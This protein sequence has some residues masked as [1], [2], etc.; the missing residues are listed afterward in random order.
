VKSQVDIEIAKAKS[1]IDLELNSSKMEISRLNFS[2][3]VASL[4]TNRQMKDDLNA[5][6]RDIKGTIDS[7]FKSEK[8]ASTID[9]YAKKYTEGNV[10]NIITN[11]VKINV[12]EKIQKALNPLQEQVSSLSG[13]AK[14]ARLALLAQGDD[15]VSFDYLRDIAFGNKPESNDASLKD[16][17]SATI[18]AIITTKTSVL[19]FPRQFKE[20]KTHQEIMSLLEDKNPM[21]REGALNALTVNDKS[22]LSALVVVI[23]NDSSLNNLNRALNMFNAMTGQKFDLVFYPDALNW[24]N[25]NKENF[26][27]K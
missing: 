15:R 26:I 11:E 24:W 9:L 10:N 27:E 17:A 18:Y 14:I 19:A 7:E 20:K 5:V 22:A 13:T 8:I 21:N 16:T 12:T 6:R 1:N 3:K 4:E 25:E 2:A 23:K